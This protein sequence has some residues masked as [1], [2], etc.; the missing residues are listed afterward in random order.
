MDKFVLATAALFGAARRMDTML[1]GANHSSIVGSA[2]SATPSVGSNTVTAD[3]SL[4]PVI[5]TH[6]FSPTT[7][8]AGGS[9][10]HVVVSM[11]SGQNATSGRMVDSQ[12]VIDTIMMADPVRPQEIT[13]VS[14]IT[15]AT[16]A[17]GHSSASQAV[18]TD[19]ASAER[20]AEL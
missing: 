10:T 1:F 3:L 5:D 20:H 7:S 18:A 14:Q 17:V 16:A 11:T 13:E 8:A 2:I 6:D 19:A 15:G 12:I 9:I 4:S